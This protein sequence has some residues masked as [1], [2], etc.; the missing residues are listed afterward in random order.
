MWFQQN[1]TSTHFANETIQLLREKCID[2]EYRSF[3]KN[4]D[5]Y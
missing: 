2:R 4:I 1:G 5:I 3:F